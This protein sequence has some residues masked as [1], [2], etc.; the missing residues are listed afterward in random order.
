MPEATL[1]IDAGTTSVRALIF[2]GEWNRIGRAQQTLSLK[3]PQP[4]RVEQSP[5]ALWDSTL[6]VIEQS[7]REAHL[8]ANDVAALGITSQRATCIVWEKSTG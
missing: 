7:L 5:E 6:S 4:G 3:T 8:T 1:A 2:D